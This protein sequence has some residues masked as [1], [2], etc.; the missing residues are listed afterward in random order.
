[1]E[2]I[3]KHESVFTNHQG[4]LLSDTKMNFHRRPTENGIP[5]R[6]KEDVLIM[7]ANNMMR[8]SSFLRHLPDPSVFF[9]HSL[10]VPQFPSPALG[11]IK[12]PNT[13]FKQ[14][15]SRS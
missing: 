10:T 9:P 13:L 2:L 6:R 12:A 14:G 7:I 1:M 4:F 11:D 8:T 3:K 5:A 15:V